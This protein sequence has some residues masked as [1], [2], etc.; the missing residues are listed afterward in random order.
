MD[1]PEAKETPPSHD[2]RIELVIGPMFSGKIRMS[3]QQQPDALYR[4]P[5]NSSA[6]SSSVSASGGKASS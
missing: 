6:R 4:I 5:S 3:M 2:G 1:P